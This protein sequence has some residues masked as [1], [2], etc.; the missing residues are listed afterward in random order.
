MKGTTTFFILRA[1][2]TLLWAN[3]ALKYFI[4]KSQNYSCFQLTY[5]TY[6]MTDCDYNYNGSSICLLHENLYTF[7]QKKICSF[8]AISVLR[9]WGEPVTQLALFISLKC[10][11]WHTAVQGLLHPKYWVQIVGNSENMT[12]ILTL[13]KVTNET[14]HSGTITKAWSRIC[15]AIIQ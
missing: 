5:N 15:E 2:V 13:L 12:V 11:L 9:Q 7:I 3:I 1:N 10:L 8:C 4:L 6:N 14:H